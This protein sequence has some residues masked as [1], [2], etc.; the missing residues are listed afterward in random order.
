MKRGVLVAH[1]EAGS[2]AAEAG[3]KGATSQHIVDG[4]TWAADGDI[5]VQADGVFTPT[6]NRLSDVIAQHKPGDTIKLVVYHRNSD[7]TT[8]S[9]KTIEVKLGR[10]RSS[11]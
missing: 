6:V 11:P 9:K 10:Q 4:V 3:L 5:V 8:Y 7:N 1:V 2:G